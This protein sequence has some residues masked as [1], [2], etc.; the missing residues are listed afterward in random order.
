M[1]LMSVGAL[2]PKGLIAQF[3]SLPESKA[4]WWVKQYLG[5]DFNSD[6]LYS[7][8]SSRQ[9]TII[10]GDS[11]FILNG[12]LIPEAIGAIYDNAQGQIYYHDF[13]GNFPNQTHLLYDFDVEIGDTIY[14]VLAGAYVF[15]SIY[16]NTVDSVQYASQ[17]RKRI[18]ISCNPGALQPDI[19]WVQ[20]IGAI[21]HFVNGGGIIHGACDALSLTYKLHCFSYNDTIRYGVNEGMPGQCYTFIGINESQASSSVSIRSGNFPGTFILEH[22]YAIEIEVYNTLGDLLLRTNGLRFDISAQPPGIYIV[23]LKDKEFVLSQKV[24]R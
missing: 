10:T 16:V 20:G 9:D 18:G 2:L 13:N 17:W 22:D 5:P 21:E 4:Q 7:L 15:D 19:H 3:E 14:D 8:P 12:Y 11:F 1:M 6:L 23:R 24:L